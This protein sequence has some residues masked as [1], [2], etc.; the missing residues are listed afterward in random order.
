MKPRIQI[1]VVS[2]VVAAMLSF[3]SVVSAGQFAFAKAGPGPMCPG[4]DP[5]VLVATVCARQAGRPQAG[6]GPMCPSTTGC[7]K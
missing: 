5:C 4:T 7:A 6:P 1:V 2:I 3:P